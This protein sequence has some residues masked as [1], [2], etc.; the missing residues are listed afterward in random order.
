MGI[1]RIE[2]F[3]FVKFVY[4]KYF[5]SYDFIVLEEIKVL[6]IFK[7]LIEYYFEAVENRVYKKIRRWVIFFGEKI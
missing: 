7:L 1:R 2:K 5:I 4:Y 3:D 6:V